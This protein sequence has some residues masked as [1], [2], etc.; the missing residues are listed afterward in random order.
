MIIVFITAAFF[1]LLSSLGASLVRYILDPVLGLQSVR[2]AVVP[3]VIAQFLG[4]C[5]FVALYHRVEAVIEHSIEKTEAEQQV[6]DASDDNSATNTDL[7]AA[8]LKLELN[9]VASGLA[10]G[11]GFG[12]MH[13]ILLFG[14]LLALETADLGVLLQPSCPLPS[15]V[16]SGLNCFFFF[17]LDLFWMLFTFFGMR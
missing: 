13:A 12:G 8:K 15:L 11:T 16:V 17:F 14:S 4:R 2:S 3:S 1:F 7:E 6:S 5:S 10:A 9:D